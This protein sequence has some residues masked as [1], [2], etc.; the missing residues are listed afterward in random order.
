LFF[1]FRQEKAFGFV[2][3]LEFRRGLAR[4]GKFKVKEGAAT[5]VFPFLLSIRNLPLVWDVK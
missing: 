5:T 2:M 3:C 4:I 1:F